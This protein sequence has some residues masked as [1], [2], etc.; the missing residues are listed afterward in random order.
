MAANTW[1]WQVGLFVCFIFLV[2]ER[3]TLD[4]RLHVLNSVLHSCMSRTA[5]CRCYTMFCKC[6]AMPVWTGLRF[7]VCAAGGLMSLL[8]KDR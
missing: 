3:Q 7:C 2:A 6:V 5:C 8:C 4:W 1:S